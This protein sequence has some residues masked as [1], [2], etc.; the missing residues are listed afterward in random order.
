MAMWGRISKGKISEKS[1]LPFGSLALIITV[2][3]GAPG[4][5][6]AEAAPETILLADFE[7]NLDGF[8]EDLQRDDS[9]SQSGKFS[10]RLTNPHDGWVEVGKDLT[11]LHRDVCAVKLWVKSNKA[12]TLSVRFVDA[13]G[14]NFQQT[15][16]FEPDDAWHQLKINN[17]ATDVQ[18]W[19]GVEDKQWHPP[20]KRL[21][22]ILEDGHNWV[23]FDRIEAELSGE[24][25]L[26][27]LA[28]VPLAAGNVF[29]R[30]EK[31]ALAV[32]TRGDEVAFKIEDFWAKEIA[33][34]VV[35]PQAGRAQ[36]Q[37]ELNQPGYYFVRLETKAG[38]KTLA[39]GFSA[40]VLLAS[41]FKPGGPESRFGVMTHFAQEW[42]T[43]VLPIL[44]KAGIGLVRDELYWEAVEPKAGQYEFPALFDNYMKG[45]KEQGLTPLIEMTF[46]NPH[47][48]AGHAPA[49]D[50]GREAYA[51]YGEALLKHYGDQI[52]WLEIWNEYNG[53]WCG[54]EAEKD[55]PAY[56]ARMLKTAAAHLKKIRPDVQLLGGATVLIPLPYLEKQFKQGALADMDGIAVHP[57]RNQPEG[58]EADLTQLKALMR[59]YNSG[60]EVPI[61]ITETG[62]MSKAEYPWEAG[63]KMY[64]QGRRIGA[65]YLA[66]QYTLLLSENAA[67]IFWYLGRDYQDFIGMGLLRAPDSPLGRYAAT[68][69][70]AAYANLIRQLSGAKF[71]GREAQNSRSR[72]YHF[73]R[74]EK[75]VRI[76]WS[77]QER[78]IELAAAQ[79]LS[80][81]DL[82]GAESTLNPTAGKI[83]LKLD[84]NPVYV[85][86]P[87]Q[88]VTET[89]FGPRVLTEAYE[90][91]SFEQGR[92]DWHYGYAAIRAG[93]TYAPD[94]FKALELTADD[95]SRNWTGP[96]GYLSLGAE[97]AHPGRDDH[98][99]YW[100]VRR[101]ISPAAGQLTLTGEFAASPDG[102]DG[103]TAWIWAA[104][105]QLLQEKLAAGQKKDFTLPLAV[106]PGTKIDFAV[107]S[108]PTTDF[109]NTG[110]A[111]TITQAR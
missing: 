64:E 7:T 28:V 79:P 61:W 67:K 24:L 25:F 41:E 11:G 20:A 22:L 36:I 86:G 111:V 57:Y 40:L 107:A 91:F 30:P 52:R 89:T 65:G 44:A 37:T 46:G 74:D 88:S 102:G 82:F 106:S 62:C 104:G 5:G 3:F 53:S 17:R 19:G 49:T 2:L 77:R 63:R 15:V 29:V 31:P 93:E 27:E 96:V 105:R 100:A 85:L 60:R 56:Y 23:Q 76:C 54:G 110:F 92:H 99:E 58:V 94:K 16:E 43:D 55:R 48:D 10:A 71:I 72:V 95:W 109:D 38:G 9:A 13:T 78:E 81:I 108:G 73:Q 84:L 6:A 14:Q 75:D 66:R 1:R 101:W 98:S 87:V 97:S 83:R 4:A 32:D 12:T 69:A 47:Y 80:R 35:K 90:D 70:Y 50:A 68:P 18:V 51:R 42:S 34:G 8:S 45:L 59:Q 39:A 21:D 33:A 26:P 103:V